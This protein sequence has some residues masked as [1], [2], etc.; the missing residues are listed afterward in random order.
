MSNQTTRRYVD[1]RR[2]LG[3]VTW[4]SCAALGLDRVWSDEKHHVP[5]QPRPLD[6]VTSVTA[7]QQRPLSQR[8]HSAD[9]SL[10]KISG[11]PRERGLAYGRRFATEISQFLEKEV[12]ATFTTSTTTRDRMLRYAAACLKPIRA[13][14]P[15]IAEELEGMAEGSGRRLE[16]MVSLLLHEEFCNRGVLPAVDHCT[17]LAVGPPTTGDHCTYVAQS[18]DW[19]ERLY[20]KSQMLLWDRGAE[21]PSV[22]AYSYPGLWIATGMNSAGIALCWTSVGSGQGMTTRDP[23]VGVPTYVLLAHLLY[24][25]TL[26]AVE[27]EARRAKLAGWFTFVMADAEGHILNFEG[28][29]TQKKVFERGRGDLV[30]VYYGTREMTGTPPG[31]PVQRHPQYQRMMDLVAGSRGK[32]DRSVLQGFYGDHQSTICKHF[33]TLDVMVYNTTHREAYVSRGP[34]CLGRWQRFTFETDASASH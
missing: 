33:A 22:V 27:A 3:A 12:F 16:E 31:K 11:V 21:G 10:V 20:G 19:Y 30:R 17:A 5:H 24:Q 26:K 1:R 9:H 6:V 28:A 15:T 32:I 7:S 2:F 14:S 18:W 29:S 13:L 4:G 23:A 25:P 8:P 34:G